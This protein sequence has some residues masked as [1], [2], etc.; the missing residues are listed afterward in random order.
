MEKFIE[1]IEEEVKR[2][3]STFSQ[4]PMIKLTNALKRGQKT[5]EKCHMCLKEFNDPQNKKVTATTRAYIE[6]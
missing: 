6:E 2:L 1:Y 3:Y 4:Q 5:P